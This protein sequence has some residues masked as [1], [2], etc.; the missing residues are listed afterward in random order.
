MS[1]GELS[2]ITVQIPR[3]EPWQPR[4]FNALYYRQQINPLC[5]LNLEFQILF[6]CIGIKVKA[7]SGNIKAF[8]GI[9]CEA[10]WASFWKAGEKKSDRQMIQDIDRHWERLIEKERV[11]K[12]ANGS[13][14][15]NVFRQN[16]TPVGG[17]VDRMAHQGYY[18]TKPSCWNI[19][20]CLQNNTFLTEKKHVVS[21]PLQC[22]GCGQFVYFRFMFIWK[23]SPAFPRKRLISSIPFP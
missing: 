22:N 15:L 7:H 19:S 12:H 21:S 16:E 10:Q 2:H 4:D 1:Q 23:F 8:K 14:K 3:I 11:R 5:Q 6:Q 17:S 20:Y 18:I 13:H 9:D